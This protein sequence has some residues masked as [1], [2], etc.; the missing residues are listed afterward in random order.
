MFSATVEPF[1]TKILQSRK[2]NLI[3]IGEPGVGKTGIVEGFAQ[4]LT[5]GQAAERVGS[6]AVR[7]ADSCPPGQW[8]EKGG[9]LCRCACALHWQMWAGRPHS[10]KAGTK[11]RGEVEERAEALVREASQ[12]ATLRSLGEERESKPI[13]FIGETGNT[14]QNTH[15][16]HPATPP[17]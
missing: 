6:A 17:Y 7:R 3:L 2:N 13:L 4:L 16:R 8:V 12:G 1:F 9:G 15:A 10:L 11:Y 14:G 5:G